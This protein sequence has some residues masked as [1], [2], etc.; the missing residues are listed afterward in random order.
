MTDI[1]FSFVLVPENTKFAVLFSSQKKLFT[2]RNF[3]FMNSVVFCKNVSMTEGKPKQMFFQNYVRIFV[4]MKFSAR[5]C[6]CDGFCTKIPKNWRKNNTLSVWINLCQNTCWL[7]YS[8]TQFTSILRKFFYF[9]KKFLFLI[10]RLFLQKKTS[11]PHLT[12]KQSTQNL[13]KLNKKS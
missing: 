13:Q 3:Q 7:K 4:L 9:L 11:Q 1:L 10:V 8:A 12:L 5:N 2:F 6:H